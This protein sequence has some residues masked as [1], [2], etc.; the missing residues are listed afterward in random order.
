MRNLFSQPPFIKYVFFGSIGINQTSIA[1][2]KGQDKKKEDKKKP[3]K[4]LDEKRAEKK[5]KR[6]QKKF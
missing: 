5:A 3:L 2:S 1:M 4:T 6:E